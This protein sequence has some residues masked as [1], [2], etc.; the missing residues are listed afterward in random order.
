MFFL[1]SQLSETSWTAWVSTPSSTVST[2]TSATP[3]FFSRWVHTSLT[4]DHWLSPWFNTWQLN[5]KNCSLTYLELAS[6]SSSVSQVQVQPAL[7]CVDGIC[8]GL[9]KSSL[10]YFCSSLDR[11]TF[12][13]CC[14]MMIELFWHLLYEFTQWTEIKLFRPTEPA[15]WDGHANWPWCEWMPASIW[16]TCYRRC[17]S[18]YWTL[19]VVDRSHY[20]HSVFPIPYAYMSSFWTRSSL[21]LSTGARLTNLHLRRWVPRWR[22]SRTATTL[23]SL[24]RA[25]ASPWSVSVVLTSTLATRHWPSVSNASCR[26]S[27][28]CL[29]SWVLP[30]LVSSVHLCTTYLGSTLFQAYLDSGASGK[31]AACPYICW[32]PA[33]HICFKRCYCCATWHAYR[34]DIV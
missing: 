20:L 13:L 1:D 24:P 28:C 6:C 29:L 33:R 22:P 2:R 19:V 34:C 30:S 23:S 26:T 12:C 17:V 5:E 15:Q 21:V 11:L 9:T 8:Y 32:V 3:S 31:S 16:P 18:G 7:D 27:P 10:G 4:V 25:W 14:V